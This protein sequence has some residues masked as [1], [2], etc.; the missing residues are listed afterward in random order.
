V[1]KF[2]AD[3]RVYD[4]DPEWQLPEPRPLMKAK[5]YMMQI[6]LPFVS[7]L[8]DVIWNLTLQVLNLQEENTRQKNEI[9]RCYGQ[10]D[11][12]QDRS[13]QLQDRISEMEQDRMKLEYVKREIG[14][15][16]VEKM[17]EKGLREDRE[18]ELARRSRRRS[19]DM[20]L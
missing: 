12:L 20:S 1:K 13:H 15:E 8:K 9:A 7:K 3:V 5:N 4:E 6:V 19:I 18:L 2:E 10:I 11:N 17:A 16:A 14:S